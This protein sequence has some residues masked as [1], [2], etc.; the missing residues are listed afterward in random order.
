MSVVSH[1]STDRP[2]GYGPRSTIP[3]VGFVENPEQIL[4]QQRRQNR[5][6][7]TIDSIHSGYMEYSSVEHLED[8]HSDC[9]NHSIELSFLLEGIT[10]IDV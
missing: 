10:E 7:L 9:H 6:A 4:R 5:M 8:T 2:P 3:D 1:G